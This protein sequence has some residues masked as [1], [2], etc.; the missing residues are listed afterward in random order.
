MQQKYLLQ[1]DDLYSEDF[2]LTRLPLL[3][4]EVRGVERLRAFSARL[5]GPASEGQGQADGP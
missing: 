4:E 1:M 5:L 2:H 3:K